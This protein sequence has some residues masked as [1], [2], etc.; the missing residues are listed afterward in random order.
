MLGFA[1]D[2]ARA[3]AIELSQAVVEFAPNG[4]V[5]RG[6]QRF[7]STMGYAAKDVRGQH[8]KMFMPVEDRESAAYRAF[9][10]SLRR[11]EFQAGE[12]RRLGKGGREIWL[13][14]TYTPIRG[15][16]GRV[17]KV[18]KFAS[19]ITQAKQR[20][21]NHE[22]QVA[23]INRVQAVIEFDLKGTI[24]HAN[25]NFLSVMGYTLEEIRG[26][27]HALFVSP[28]ERTSPEYRAFW[29]ALRRGECKAGE[30]RRHGN[31]G[32]EVWIQA[33]YNPVLDAA[34]R[35]ERVVKFATD[36]TQ[37]KLRA[38]D[39]EGQ[40]TA[41]NRVQAVIEFA[42]NGTILDANP[43]FLSAMGYTLEEIRGQHH[44]MFVSPEERTS[45][46]YRAFWDALRRGE[47]KAGEFS[48]R[49]KDGREVW[50]QASYNPVFD[51]GGKPL[52]V[53]K[54]ATDITVEMQRRQ[55]FALLSLVADET[56]NS[57]IIADREG[58]IEYANPGFTRLTG[59]TV[60]EAIGRKP[61]HLL[62]GRHTDPETVRRI[63]EHLASRKPFYEEILN[64]TKTDEPYWVSLSINPVL[65]A[66][67]DV[68]RFVSV[69]ANVSQTKQRAVEAGARLD[70]IERSNVVIEWDVDGSVV[71]LNELAR[72]LLGVSSAR[73]EDMGSLSHSCLLSETDRAALSGGRCV[74]LDFEFQSGGRELFLSGTVQPL[75]DVEGRLRRTV[76]YAVD[77]SVRRRAI[78]E[79]ERVMTAML[80]RIS[81]MATDISGISNQTNLLALNATI[82]AARA[83]DAGKGF[84]VVASEVKSLAQRSSNST[85]EISSLVADTRAHI[86]QLI[87]AA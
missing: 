59:Y 63:G 36:I 28:E 15:F 72:A 55:S 50:I 21:A 38:A 43:N 33:S 34:G 86:E 69:Q 22:G 7:L 27:H 60:E 52:K 23:A 49:G 58:L 64:Y 62:Q 16:G 78:R 2:R 75:L 74:S 4:T 81:R 19:D 29:D 87:A 79:A 8:H 83:G 24:L 14:A 18:V 85:G 31:G 42:L 48:R 44:A 51:P 37:A 6:N 47:F 12:F 57:V 67:G 61:G 66:D 32:R 9:W 82:E 20:A 5:L 10:E 35:P 25:P 17:I 46:E 1:G 84:A 80:D 11:G 73:S 45:P 3:A 70:A 68:E 40:M 76:L 30:F 54:F 77:M 41:I 39:H 13:Q 71:D 56:D 65:G 26:Q 53:V